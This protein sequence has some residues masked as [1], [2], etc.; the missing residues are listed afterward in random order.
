MLLV[1]RF[2]ALLCSQQLFGS[3]RCMATLQLPSKTTST[4]VYGLPLSS[5]QPYILYHSIKFGSDQFART[6]FSYK[7]LLSAPSNLPKTGKYKNF[8][9]VSSTFLCFPSVYTALRSKSLGAK[10]SPWLLVVQSRM[11]SIA[12]SRKYSV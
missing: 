12:R 2:A 6:F 8:R 1:L 5:P 3:I 11:R 7:Y 4:Y 9:V 10:Q